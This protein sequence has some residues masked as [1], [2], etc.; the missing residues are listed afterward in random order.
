MSTFENFFV[1]FWVGLLTAIFYWL[2]KPL[3]GERPKTKR[4]IVMVLFCIG[5]AI[6]AEALQLLQ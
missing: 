4:F 6:A 2:I 5:S 1:M 3:V